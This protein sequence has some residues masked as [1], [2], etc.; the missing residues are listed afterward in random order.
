MS[1]RRGS[2]QPR[3]ADHGKLIA[4]SRP[5]TAFLR[6][7]WFLVLLTLVVAAGLLGGPTLAARVE[8][9]NPKVTTVI[10]LFLMAYSLDSRHVYAALRAPGPVVWA[11]LV[12]YGLIPLLAWPLMSLQRLPDFAT[13][14]MI[15]ASVPCTLATASVWTRKA[16]GNDAVSLLVTLTTNALCLVLTP[17]WLVLTTAQSVRLNPWEMSATLAGTVLGPTLIG[18]A[19]RLSA[20][21]RQVAERRKT[22][23]NV[24]AQLL[25]LLLVLTAASKG[26]TVLRTSGLSPGWWAVAVVWLSCIVLHTG[27]ALIGWRGSRLLGHKRKDAIAVTFAGSQ[28][29]LPIGLLLATD[30]GLFG[31]LDLPFLVFPML[32]YHI[33]QLF[34]DT[35]LA[36]RFASQPAS[37]IRAIV[38]RPRDN[39]DPEV[40]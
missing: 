11:G 16:G 9:V 3:L 12:N 15:T 19:A 21:S 18:Q 30:K 22:V 36:H 37:E 23:I 7:H 5:L 34:I 40:D 20:R 1:H 31:A 6:Q 33:S 28:K 14:L 8:R 29:T 17:L 38:E 32:L 2:I 24:A 10:V 25:V 39:R 4:E 27:A 26:G 35:W 13:G